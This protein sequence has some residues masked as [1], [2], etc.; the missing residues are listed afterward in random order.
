MDKEEAK[1]ILKIQEVDLDIERINKR[2]E[3]IKEEAAKLREELEALR[4]EREL[5]LKR[6]DELESLRKKLTE[7]IKEA[8]EKLQRTEDRLMKVKRDV[9]YKAL[10]REKAKLEDRILKRSYE[11]DEVKREIEKLTKEIQERVPRIE[12]E[13][14]YLEEEIQDLD[15]EEKLSHKKLHE[16]LKKREEIKK[17]I[18]E[19]LLRMYESSKEHYEGFVIVP[20]E[21]EACSG[22]GIRIPNVLLTKILKENSIEQCPSCGRFIYYKL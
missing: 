13:I 4:K 1:L 22:C 3:S 6:K 20:I 17:E 16:Y 10:L 15:V 19:H 5:L 18:P 9:D 21:E 8:E 7:E 11:L 14:S 12:R 2:I